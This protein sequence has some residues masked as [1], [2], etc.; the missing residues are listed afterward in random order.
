MSFFMKYKF[1]FSFISGY[2]MLAHISGILWDLK[3]GH[4]PN[5]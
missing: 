3:L 1:V 5:H 2:A 4:L